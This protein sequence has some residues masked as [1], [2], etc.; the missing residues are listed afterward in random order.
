MVVEVLL[1]VFLQVVLAVTVVPVVEL[2]AVQ[3]VLHYHLQPVVQE[4]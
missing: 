4:V 3:P 1:P 2:L